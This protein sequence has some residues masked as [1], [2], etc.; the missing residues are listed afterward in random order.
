[1]PSYKGKYKV[2]NY[3]KYKGDPTRVVY[4]SLWERKFMDWCDKTPRVV[5]WWSEEI[6]IPYKDPVQKKWRR[7][8][9]DFWVKVKETNGKTKSYLIEVKPKRQVDGPKPQK[10][11]TKKYITE[12]MTYATNQAKWEAANDYCNDRLWEFKLITELE[13]KI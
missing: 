12:V 11:H 13:L 4:R 9:P 3:R 8:F 5:E 6:A 1:M 10:R 7:Y 2:R